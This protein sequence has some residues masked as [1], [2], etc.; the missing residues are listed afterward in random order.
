M[1]KNRYILLVVLVS[2]LA[3]TC[4]TKKN[5]FT[6]RSYHNMTAR[7]NGWYW[8]K[9][10]NKEGVD[11]LDQSHVDDYSK[12]LE[13]YRLGDDKAAKSAAN[14]FDKAITKTSTVIAKHSM[15][16]K[17]REYCK[18]IDDNYLTMA[19]AHYYKRDYYAAIE[20]LEY[21]IRQYKG[22]E[23]RYQAMIWLIRTYNSMNSVINTQAMIDLIKNDK[24]FPKK[25]EG[26]FAAVQAHHYI[27]TENYEKAIFYLTKA[28]PL[29]KSK[30]QKARY[31]FILGQLYERQG[32]LKKASQ[33]YA[34]CA[35]MNPPY[36][37]YFNAKIKRALTAGSS[38]SKDIRKELLKMAKD[39]K[40][41]EYLDQIY[42]ALGDI[43]LREADTTQGIAYL[44]Q[45]AA[46]SL[47]NVKQRGMSYVRLADIYFVQQQ[48]KPAQAYYDSAA[49]FL[50]KD[51]KDYPIVVNKKTSLTSLVNNLKVISTE[52]SLLNV[53]AMD[54]LKRK[55]LIDKIIAD[56]V[57]EEKKKEEEKLNQ[58][59][60]P[61][62]NPFGTVSNTT[63][64]NNQTG[65]A[66]Y[67]Y[68]P[69]A[70][71]FGFSEFLKQ[72]GP[73]TLEDHWRRS[74]KDPDGDENNTIVN[75]TPKDTVKSTKLA[76]N[77]K[78]EYYLQNLPLTAEAKEKSK[79]RIIDAYYNVGSIYKEQL[80]D[81]PRAIATFEEMNKRFPKNKYELQNYYQLYRLN[82][83]LK[84][85]KESDVYKNII[86]K[87]YP[88]S[89]YAKI[90]LNP[91]YA[92]QMQARK[93][94]IENYYDETYFLYNSGQY[95]QVIARANKADSI[96]SKSDL[97]PKFALL[98]AY[99]IG[100]TGDLQAYENALN[101]IIIK[102]P[103]DPAKQKAQTLLDT[104]KKMKT[105]SDTTGSSVKNEPPKK[106]LFKLHK[107]SSH[108]VMVLVPNKQ[109]TLMSFKNKLSNFNSQ[110]FGLQK[111]AIYNILYDSETQ[112][113]TVR[114]FPNAAKA[115]E[116]Y[117]YLINNKEMMSGDASS[118]KVVLI[119]AENFATFY[120]EKKKDEYLK[121]F[122]ENYIKNK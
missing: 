111:L 48:Y 52:D 41:K 70:I 31:V 116:Y 30:K 2:L 92:S 39:E 40:N 102:Y 118:Y 19:Q 63:N 27:L 96:Y 87:N 114:T 54:T 65:G 45:S 119:S 10:S 32:D 24:D 115:N 47:L 110:Y 108:Y 79:I 121:F 17:D 68:N 98:R 6:S 15:L 18:W 20:V 4:S 99:A 88:E 61:N 106:E 34:Q 12:V 62:N 58:Q 66:W 44:K 42:Y 94:E 76:D 77:K 71:S 21:I 105:G 81:Y 9:E 55:Q 33:Y 1:N 101:K 3:W 69:S 112:V 56:L 97:M 16:I 122:D 7:Y 35:K 90:I 93:D 50:P 113:I 84:K 5:T 107:D 103:K 51:Y 46:S 100:H 82:L 64:Q 67:F 72:W 29:T 26:E 53:A 78:P 86:L 23:T 36:E 28:I 22:T 11:K 14:F 95:E 60:N 57:A 25:L 13:M 43:S 80:K 75:E 74:V 91:E 89:E 49:A 104:L 38:D 85:Q 59:N 117:N 8:A 120:K 73:R 83:Q 109:N 37:M